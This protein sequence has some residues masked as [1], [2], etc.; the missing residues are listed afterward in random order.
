ME[1]F[2]KGLVGLANVGK[3]ANL[4]IL[5]VSQM[6][7]RRLEPLTKGCA[8]QDP[9]FAFNQGM[10]KGQG[11]HVSVEFSLL[12]HVRFEVYFF[13]RSVLTFVSVSCN[14]VGGRC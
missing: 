8:L 12:Y 14:D 13:D 10:K 4:D 1:D 11:H 5:K 3:S 9:T 2:V 7:H 6:F